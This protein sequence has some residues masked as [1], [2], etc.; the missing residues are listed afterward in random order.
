MA[1]RRSRSA[2][3]GWRAASRSV[4]VR[5]PERPRQPALRHAVERWAALQLL[6]PAVSGLREVN[7]RG[8]VCCW[9]RLG[10][11][12]R[13]DDA[14]G[15]PELRRAAALEISVTVA[16]RRRRHPARRAD[17][18]HEPQRDRALRRA[19]PRAQRRRTLLMVEHDMGVVF[20][21]ADRIAVLAQGG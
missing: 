7:S 16:G 6:A 11:A 1:W 4:A 15:Q 20:E 18:R 21:L 8:P 17:R 19:D 14:G 5:A 3:S 9:N 13:R 10:L 12:P 2:G